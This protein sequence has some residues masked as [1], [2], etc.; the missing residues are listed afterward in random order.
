MRSRVARTGRILR[1]AV[2]RRQGGILR[3][4]S[5]PR[6]REDGRGLGAAANAAAAYAV[7]APLFIEEWARPRSPPPGGCSYCRGDCEPG[8]LSSGGARQ[9]RSQFR[10]GGGFAE[11]RPNVE[12]SIF[13]PRKLWNLRTTCSDFR[14]CDGAAART[15]APS[16]VP[17]SALPASRLALRSIKRCRPRVGA[18]G[19]QRRHPAAAVYAVA[20]SQLPAL[21]QFSRSRRLRNVCVPVFHAPLAPWGSGVG[22]LA[23]SCG[24]D[25]GEW[26]GEDVGPLLR[27]RYLAQREDAG[28]CSDLHAVVLDVNV[29]R[30]LGWAPGVGHGDRPCVVD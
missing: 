26:L 10:E 14:Q 27:A 30:A 2:R 25:A 15:V 22:E 19:S 21:P 16:P 8:T 9:G 18:A 12:R 11:H 23:C 6:P 29:F 4:M 3:G 17:S 13:G 5:R 20:G 28:R 24:R 1:R 7:T